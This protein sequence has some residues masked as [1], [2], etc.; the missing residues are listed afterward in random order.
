MIEASRPASARPTI[1]LD[2]LLSM[3]RGVLSF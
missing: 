3:N 2:V 1:S